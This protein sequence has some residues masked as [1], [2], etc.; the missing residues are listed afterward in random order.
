MISRAGALRWAPK[1]RSPPEGEGRLGG[2]RGARHWILLIALAL[3]IAFPGCALR[4]MLQG[5]GAESLTLTNALGQPV[6]VVIVLD[7]D[8]GGIRLIGEEV[9]LEAGQS[10]RYE[11]PMRPGWHTIRVTTSTSIAETLRVD[12]REKG[13]TDILVT[14]VRGKATL[15][16]TERS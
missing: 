7:Q 13:D 10:K 4:Q 9:F 8:E 2:S 15:T 11:P 6:S 1:V 3:A 16:V 12:I 5:E 14:I